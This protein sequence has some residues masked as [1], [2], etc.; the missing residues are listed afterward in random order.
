MNPVSAR[1]RSP[2]TVRPVA[3]HSGRRSLATGSTL[4]LRVNER[5]ARLR[6]RMIQLAPVGFQKRVADGMRWRKQRPTRG[7]TGVEKLSVPLFLAELELHREEGRTEAAS[8]L[9]GIVAEGQTIRLAADHGASI[10]M[11]GGQLLLDLE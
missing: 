1:R 2:S 7:V 3:S 4:E 8:E 5:V 11:S 10:R 6:V 9:V